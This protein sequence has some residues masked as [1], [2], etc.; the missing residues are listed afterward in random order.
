MH[1]CALL[2]FIL[3]LLSIGHKVCEKILHK[4]LNT[5]YK[6]T[7]IKSIR[8]F[9][10]IIFGITIIIATMSIGGSSL[11]GVKQGL[12]FTE[13]LSTAWYFISTTFEIIV[14]AVLGLLVAVYGVNLGVNLIKG[15]KEPG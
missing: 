13:V 8:K 3:L 7:M 11:T 6:Y 2:I 9:L 10:R 12:S 5:S 15:N 4:E 14:P 1:T